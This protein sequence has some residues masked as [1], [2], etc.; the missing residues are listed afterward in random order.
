MRKSMIVAGV[1]LYF[2]STGIAQ[3]A[4]LILAQTVSPMCQV[5]GPTVYS[6]SVT[7]NGL[8]SSFYGTTLRYHFVPVAGGAT[9]VLPSPTPAASPVKL[10]VPAGAYKLIISP[11]QVLGPG[12]SQSPQYPVTVPGNLTLNLWSK[13][14]CNH[15]YVP[16]PRLDPPLVK[17]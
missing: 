9:I 16:A 6:V 12:A 1:C 11:N 3:A 10:A 15:R 7:L 4:P 17:G 2:L 5:Q 8:T 13:K 14:I